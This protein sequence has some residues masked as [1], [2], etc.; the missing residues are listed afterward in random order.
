LLAERIL[1]GTSANGPED[2]LRRRENISVY[3]ASGKSVSS[4]QP[5]YCHSEP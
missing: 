1:T 3:H 5:M 2:G 4:S